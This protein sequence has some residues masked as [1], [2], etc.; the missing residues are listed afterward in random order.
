MIEDD[1]DENDTTTPPAKK[2]TPPG[3]TPFPSP[4][5][6]SQSSAP[7]TRRE[8]FV[9]EVPTTPSRGMGRGYITPPNR[10]RP[11]MSERDSIITDSDR[12]LY[13]HAEIV[14]TYLR[15]LSPKTLNF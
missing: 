3:R 7:S 13:N 15:K 2:N 11:G 6:N 14:E 5:K 4:E 8:I 9:L 12:I 1:N 10:G